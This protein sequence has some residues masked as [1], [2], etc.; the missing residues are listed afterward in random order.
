MFTKQAMLL[1]RLRGYLG[2]EP[3]S[4]I[5]QLA[6]CQAE[7]EHRGPLTLTGTRPVD[8][9]DAMLMIDNFP[10]KP[11][12]NGALPGVNGLNNG[13]AIDVRKGS[14]RFR[15]GIVGEGW[16]AKASGDW[17]DVAGNYQSY[18]DCVVCT[19]KDGTEL[20]PSQTVRIYLPRNSVM[21]PNVRADDVIHFYLDLNGTAICDDP[22]VMDLPIGSK[23]ELLAGD[24]ADYPSRGWYI[25][26]GTNSTVN[27]GGGVSY[28]YTGVAPFDTVGGTVTVALTGAT[29]TGSGTAAL[30]IAS[31]N[32]GTHGH[33]NT[34]A[35]PAHTHTYSGTVNA[36]SSHTHTL[37]VTGNDGTVAAGTADVGYPVGGVFTTSAGSS[38]DHGFSGTTSGASATTL[39]GGITDADLGSHG[40]PG[41]TVSI[42]TI[43]GGL[44]LGTPSAIRPAGYTTLVLQRM[45]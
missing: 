31:A 42:S 29:I 4:I 11:Q 45:N 14:V 44:S 20:V 36:E 37:T 26:N 43:A 6:N 9:R 32:L 41:S 33:S 21:D 10:I 17:V 18:V 40:H 24:P 8:A 19:D 13:W 38:H 15:G 7:L 3:T 1:E 30:T 39:T 22:F 27:A 12:Q 16:W 2:D 34:L 35:A 5:A 25:A 23:R 28:G